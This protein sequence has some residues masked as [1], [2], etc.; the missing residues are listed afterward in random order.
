MKY[1]VWK[2]SIRDIKR[3]D[4]FSILNI[5]GL[6]IGF[7]FIILIALFVNREKT[8]DRF[9][10]KANSIFMLDAKVRAEDGTIQKITK[11]SNKEI[12]IRKL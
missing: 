12:I 2:T 3:L 4:K 11:I 6:G 5:T 1:P 10:A 9:H 8:Y 7:T